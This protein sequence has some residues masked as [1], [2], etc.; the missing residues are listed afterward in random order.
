MIRFLRQ[1]VLLTA[2]L[3]PLSTLADE[4]ILEY[5]SDI[6]VHE[7]G[8][9]TVTELIRVQAEGKNIRRGIYRDFPTRY[10]DRLGN[11][12]KVDFIPLSVHRN[13]NPEACTAKRCQT[14]FVSTP[15]AKAGR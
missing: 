8:Q 15:V 13:G 1:L 5:R 6:H 10:R 14:V 11:Y 3:V 9:L 7:N 4:R 2:C 12:I